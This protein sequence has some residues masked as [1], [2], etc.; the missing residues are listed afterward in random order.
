MNSRF[1]LEYIS[2]TGA[3]RYYYPDFVIRLTDDACMIV[4]TKGLEDPDV[5]HKDQRARRWCRDATALAGRD[6]AYAKVPQKTFDAYVGSTVE[7]L[8]RFL[9]AQGGKQEEIK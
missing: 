8:Q 6:W 5:P 4:E 9:D 2:T 3:L 7:G 1:A